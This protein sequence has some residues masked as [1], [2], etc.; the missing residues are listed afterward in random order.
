[1]A[2]AGIRAV[3]VAAGQWSG[4]GAGVVDGQGRCCG[5][6]EVNRIVENG[7]AWLE[8]NFS[9][10]TNPNNAAGAG[11]AARNFIRGNL[12][13]YL[14]GLERTGRMT[15][16]R[17]IGDHDWYREG[18]D[19]LVRAQDNLSGVWKGTGHSERNPVM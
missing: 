1:M 12:L 4:G 19:M 2:C 9:V 3:I 18:C 13:Y 17:F 11:L 14:Y 15:A 7:L 16:Q 5:T 10:Y 6:Q 8:R